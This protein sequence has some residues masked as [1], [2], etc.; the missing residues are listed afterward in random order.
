MNKSRKISFDLDHNLKVYNFVDWK[1]EY[2][3]KNDFEKVYKL[4]DM[5]ELFNGDCRDNVLRCIR[6]TGEDFPSLEMIVEMM[7]IV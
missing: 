1:N 7:Q 6:C 5:T 3:A 4:K 2:P